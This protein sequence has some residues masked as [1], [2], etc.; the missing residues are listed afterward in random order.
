MDTLEKI[1]YGFLAGFIV[2]TILY[3]AIFSGDERYIC[4]KEITSCYRVIGSSETSWFYN[5]EEGIQELFK[6]S[7]SDLLDLYYIRKD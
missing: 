2:A 3:L 6:D 4:D 1:G 5:N 7:K